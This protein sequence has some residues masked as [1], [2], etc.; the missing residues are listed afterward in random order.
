MSV[1]SGGNADSNASKNNTLKEGFSIFKIALYLFRTGRKKW[2]GILI[3]LKFKIIHQGPILF[4]CAAMGID[5]SYK[6][7]ARYSENWCRS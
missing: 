6:I 7:V 2:V 4:F 3:T 5:Q 1:E